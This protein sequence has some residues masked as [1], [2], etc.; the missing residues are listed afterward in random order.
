M[1]FGRDAIVAKI[2]R[3][4]SMRVVVDSDLIALEQQSILFP[5]KIIAPQTFFTAHHEI[6]IIPALC[7]R[8]RRRRVESNPFSSKSDLA[9]FQDNQKDHVTKRGGENS[10]KTG[11]ESRIGAHQSRYN[12]TANYAGDDATDC[13]PVWNNEMLEIDKC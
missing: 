5:R 3:Y 11:R 10:A 2:Q 8:E 9:R 4:I 1:A 13:Y 7:P 6:G 12:N